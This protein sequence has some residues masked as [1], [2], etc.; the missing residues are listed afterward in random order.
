MK[1]S[2]IVAAA[3]QQRDQE[4]RDGLW[5]S[6]DEDEAKLNHYPPLSPVIVRSDMG[7]G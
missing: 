5:D 3:L 7:R 2:Q 6:N 1:G 4:E